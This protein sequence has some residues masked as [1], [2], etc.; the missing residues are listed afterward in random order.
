MN[1]TKNLTGCDTNRHLISMTTPDRLIQLGLNLGF[2]EDTG[3]LD[4]CCGYGEMLRLWNDVFGIRGTG[5]DICPAFIERGRQRQQNPE[6]VKLL[7]ADALHYADDEKY[8]VVCCTEF[9]GDIKD[10]AG[11]IAFLEKYAKPNGKLIFGRLF[12]KTD[13]PPK[14]LTDFDGE[15]ETLSAIHEKIR[16][17]GYYMTAMASDT[18]AQWENYVFWSAARDIERL[19]KNPEDTKTKAWLEKWYDI[20]FRYRRPFEG[21]ALFGIEKL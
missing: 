11:T 8:D 2:C 21:W 16:T 18:D 13:C 12:S 1:H 3:I 19:R 20:Y 7:C 5:V 10:I 4:L 6:R 9:F 17:C 15:I 14:P